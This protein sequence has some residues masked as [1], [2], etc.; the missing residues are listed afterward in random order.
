MV[1]I[2]ELSY[3]DAPRIIVTPPGP[4]SKQLLAKQ[5][6]LETRAVIYTK[7]FPFAIDSA[8][9]ATIKDVDGNTFIDW[10]GGIC[11]LNVGHNNPFVTAAVKSQMD[12]IWHSLEI[13]TEIRI[14]FL[15]KIHSVLPGNLRGHAK[16][17]LTVTGGDACEAAISLAKHV[18]G[19]STIVAFGGSYHG[20][21]QGIVS[22][23]ASRRYLQ[24]SGTV[25]HGVFHLPFPYS[26]RFP[27]PVERKGDEGKV[28]L[29]YLENLLSDE[30]S[31]L[32]T[33]AGILVEPIQGE[34]G[35]V[36][37]PNDFLPGLRELADKYQIPLIIDEVQTGFGRTGRF[38]G[39]EVTDTSP[40]IMCISKSVGAGLPLSLIAYREEYD[41][42]LPDGFHLGTYRGNPLAMAAGAATIDYIKQENLLSKVEKLG[43]K[44]KSE[45]ERIAS[46]S[47]NVGEVRGIGFM[48]GNEIVESRDSKEPSKDLAVRM[49]KTMFENGLLM[50]TCGHFGNV[51]RFMAPLIISE[52]LMQ[53]GINVYEKTVKSI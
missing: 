50:H 30:H 7:A 25:R 39:C 32:D 46:S 15:E 24:S 26:Y 4:K 40:D 14:E 6:Q 21:H 27:F 23:T 11:V 1:S 49:R 28:V 12:R 8:R 38:W 17:L 47:K 2:Q 5:S 31:G 13:P 33:P 34:G 45:F 36:V 44:T 42:N 16:T 37:P 9:G 48:I 10:V 43:D 18:T 22:L 35:Y 41:Q 19:R 29:R 52:N 51:L 20:I 53:K 3:E